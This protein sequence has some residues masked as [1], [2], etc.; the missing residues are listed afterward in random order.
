MNDVYDHA[1]ECDVSIWLERAIETD[2]P[3]WLGVPEDVACQCEKLR[4]CEQRAY[5]RGIA[6]VRGEAIEHYQQGAA[7]ERA[8]IRK[9]VEAALPPAWGLATVLAV[10]DNEGER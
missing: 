8:R 10:I 9:A 2:A 4:R 7:D 5:K 1:P 3:R 6:L